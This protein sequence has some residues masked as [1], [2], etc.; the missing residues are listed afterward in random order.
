MNFIRVIKRLILIHLLL[1]CVQA[2]FAQSIVLHGSVVDGKSLEK[3]LGVHIISQNG[4]GVISDLD[5][6]FVMRVSQGDTLTLSM[7]GYDSLD[8]VI[9]DSLRDQSM[10]LSMKEKTTL[11]DNVSV[12]DYY[13][14]NTIMRRE[15]EG[16]VPIPGVRYSDDPSEENYRL[17]VGGALTQ[18]ATAIYRMTSKKYKQEKRVY[19][20]AVQRERNSKHYIQAKKVLYE[21]LEAIGESLDEYYMVDFIY[22]VG[23]TLES[24]ARRS[25]Y[26]LVKI[27]PGEVDRYYDNLSKK[28]EEGGLSDNVI[29]RPNN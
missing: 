6:N 12:L 17:G 24:T 8:I 10:I 22:F 3:L 19:T 1:V 18:P 4:I 2:V 23:M 5:G 7:V 25:A 15:K 9:Q 27:L 16:S 26:E 28:L 29:V 21:A 20:E 14:A 13:R 11:L